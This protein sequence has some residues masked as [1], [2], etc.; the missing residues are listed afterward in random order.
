MPR[1]LDA[2]LINSLSRKKLY[3]VDLIEL[4]LATPVYFT[5]GHIDINYDSP[6]APE[7]GVQTY[8]AQGQYI[9]FGT[10]QETSD[11]R[12]GTVAVT[13][14]AVDF[15][16]LGYVLSNDYIDRRVVM[17]RV[18]LNDD[19]TFSDANVFQYFDGNITDFTISESKETATLTLQVASQFADYERANGRRTNNSSQQRFFADDVGLE[20]SPQIQTDVK[21]GRA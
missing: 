17:Y 8:L 10:V 5:N 16:T 4:H 9:G 13:F 7:S 12:V 6:T 15:T 1:N 18:V 21:W 3:V 20:F 19:Y 11:V 14:T 2:Q